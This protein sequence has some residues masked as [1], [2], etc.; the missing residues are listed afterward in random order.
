MVFRRTVK[1]NIEVKIK[2]IKKYMKKKS[3]FECHQHKKEGLEI[4]SEVVYKD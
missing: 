4:F 1:R 3:I 2:A